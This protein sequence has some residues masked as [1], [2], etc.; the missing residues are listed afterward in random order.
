MKYLL[1]FTLLLGGISARPYDKFYKPP[2]SEKL[3]LVTGCSRSGTT[4]MAEALM[5]SGLDVRHE[6]IGR[7]GSVSWPMAVNDTYSPWGP[8][9]QEGVY[10]HIFHQVRDPLKT[11]ASVMATELPRSWDFIQKHIPQIQRTDSLLVKSVKYWIYW[12][13]FAEAKAEMTYRIEDVAQVYAEIGRRI[14][15]KLDPA[16]LSRISTTTNHRYDYTHVYTWDE[17]QEI[18]PIE[19]FIELRDQAIRYGY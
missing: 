18:L 14:G 2:A 13:R 3:I 4:F 5:A 15:R 11:I 6:N 17:L 10:K 19:L 8:P 7:D 1:I 9:F 12:N 16:D